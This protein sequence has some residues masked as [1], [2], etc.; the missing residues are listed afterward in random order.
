ML[1]EDNRRGR[2]IKT[3]AVETN[4]KELSQ[5][6]WHQNNVEFGANML[7]PV[8]SP[9]NGVIAVGICSISYISGTGNIQSIEISPSQITSYTKLDNSGTRYLVGDSRGQL[10]VVTLL[11]ESGKVTSVF[12]DIIGT[13]SIPETINYLSHGIVFIGSCLGDSQLIKLHAG[14]DLSSPGN[15]CIEVLDVYTN[16]GPIL[17]MCIVDNERSGGQKQ[18]VTCSGAYKDG[19]LRIVRSGIGIQEQASLEI[20]GIKGMWSLRPSK[21]SEFDKYLVQSFISETR[22]LAIE[23]EEMG[24][25]QI[26]GFDH[27]QATLYCGNMSHDLFV[28]VTSVGV[29]L[30]DCKS[31]QLV[32]E[33]FMGKPVTVASGN[34]H[35]LVIALSGGEI[36]YLELDSS[37][38]SLQVVEQMTLDQ[39]I[40]CISMKPLHVRKDDTAMDVECTASEKSTLVSVGMWTDNTVRLLA[41]P[42]LQEVSRVKIGTDTQ[43][44]DVLIAPFATSASPMSTKENQEKVFLL[45]GMGDGILITYTID[46]SSGLPT[47][48]NRKKGVLGTHPITFTAFVSNEEFCVF[49]A[50]DR[51]SILYFR[52][53]KLLFANVD[54]RCSEVI[55]MTSFH[56]ELF[57]D[58]IALCSESSLMIGTI[59]DIQKIHVQTVSL[60]GEAPRRIAHCPVSNV[61]AVCTEKTVLSERGEEATSRVLFLDDASMTTIGEFDFDP[62]EQAISASVCRFEG[63][64]TPFFVIGTAQVV[65]EEVEPSRG[66][67]LV[68]QIIQTQDE[69]DIG[70]SSST[71]VN[72]G[73]EQKKKLVL[74]TEKETKSGVYSLCAIE[75][76]LAAGIGSKVQIYKLIVKDDSG[77]NG[78]TFGSSSSSGIVTNHV[79]ALVAELQ[80]E[81]SHQGHIMVLFLKSYNN[82]LL[83]GDL[84]R[85]VTLLH[86]RA[87]ESLI[88]EVARDFNSNYMRAVDFM[89]SMDDFCLGCDDQANIFCVRRQ[90][91]SKNEEEGMKLEVRGEFHL[92]D[93]V[94]VLC[95]G[96]LV[97]QPIESDQIP[98]ASAAGS[99]AASNALDIFDIDYKTVT[100]LPTDKYSVL[101]G[102]ISGAIGSILALNESSYRFFAAVERATKEVVNSIGNFPH[103]DW[104]NFQN[105]MRIGAQKNVIDGDLV[106][107]LLDLGREE[108]ELI[109]R[110][111]NDELSAY[112][113]SK[114]ATGNSAP[115]SAAASSNISSESASTLISNLESS[116]VEFSSDE[117]LR[118]IEDI[119]RLH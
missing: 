104:R 100:G 96:T 92:G 90:V 57:P 52:N 113:Q 87:A 2:H 5:G 98:G 42:T 26:P 58:C 8:P 44:R 86:Y 103:E 93:Y 72:N 97:S 79:A 95:R 80:S 76:R 91:E 107:M 3:W 70:A 117:I 36:Q 82:L 83:V 110:K 109:T 28:Q 41:L 63:V 40:A 43:V 61:Y 73:T 85:S 59:E 49:A 24:E 37:N 21:D 17:D 47:L 30:I 66:R 75:G 54:I 23:H 19:S 62:L 106:E 16:I 102:T 108:L 11:V 111:V 20:S 78:K 10:M 101:Y 38:H 94:N 71:D 112:L 119:S 67:I 39:D 34:T 81:C 7:I 68:F 64:S 55:K 56:S 74:V 53:D 105:E 27:E 4:E 115:G 31:L 13:T 84:V 35:Q 116:R 9:L 33:L 50:C 69:L 118:R 77:N 46:F 51:P 60:N 32:H 29:R 22:I 1:Y 15:G 18:L 25:F 48:T 45:V 89:D 12:T 88:E 65:N 6:P 114:N 14:T 99:V